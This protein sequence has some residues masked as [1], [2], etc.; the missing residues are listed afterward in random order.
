[1]SGSDS[2]FNFDTVF[3]KYK[4]SIVRL[5]F[6]YLGDYQLAQDATQET[7]IKVYKKRFSFR[8]KS[9]VNTWITRIAINTC[10]NMLRKKSFYENTTDDEE[11][12]ITSNDHLAKL[13]TK[14][15]ISQEISRLPI[16]LREVTILKYYR[17]MTV[18]EISTVLKIPQTT[19][20]YRLLQ[21][22]RRLK[23]TLKKEY[24]YD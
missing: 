11:I 9:D 13:D 12:N 17:E 8:H 3:D 22:K 15:V 20:N 7:F 2:S 18:K 14:C 4:D 1:M 23:D 19:I 24:F 16:E 21:A 5:C 10:K 6:L